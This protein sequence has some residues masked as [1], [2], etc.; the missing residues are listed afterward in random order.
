MDQQQVPGDG[1]VIGYGTINGC[2]VFVFSQDFTVFGVSH[3]EAQA[4]IICMVIDQA[5]KVGE[6]IIG[7]ND[8][9]GARIQ[10]GVASLGGY[11]EVFPHN[12][13]AS[14]VIPQNSMVM[15]PCAGGAVYSP[16]N[17]D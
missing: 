2:L 17:T 4:E 10:E 7:F 16:A 5:M 6:P 15:G 11:A 1:V 9:G 3:S 8:S 13:L 12:V 14:G